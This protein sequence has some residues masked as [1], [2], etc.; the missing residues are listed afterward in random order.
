MAIDLNTKPW[1]VAAIVGVVL[2]AALFT[3][4]H[5]YVF[6]DIK[7]DIGQLEE[8]I[9]ILEREI[10]KGLAAKA[11]LPRLEEDIRNYE[12]ELARL[13]KILP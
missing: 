6:K 3:V 7:V 8:K 10:E 11:D 9:D 12:V 5:L 2:G 13:R 4:M 1:Y